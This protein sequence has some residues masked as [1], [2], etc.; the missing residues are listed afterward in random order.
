MQKLSRIQ[1]FEWG[2]FDII[3]IAIVILQST[4]YRGDASR[5]FWQIIMKFCIINNVK[6]ATT[7]FRHQKLCWENRENKI[8][9]HK[10]FRFTLFMTHS[11]VWF[12]LLHIF[13]RN[14]FWSSSNGILFCVDCIAPSHTNHFSC[15]QC[16]CTWM[17]ITYAIIC[18]SW[19]PL[20]IK[21]LYYSYIHVSFMG[22]NI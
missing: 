13:C 7:L 11:C 19:A 14:L 9:N 18:S 2:W 8:L 12:V 22:Y 20:N 15:Q 16:S 17:W 6:S 4:S 10:Y 21:W 3:C 1:K 5:S